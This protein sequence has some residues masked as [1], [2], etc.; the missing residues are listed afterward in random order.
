MV[1]GL[2]KFKEAFAAYTDNYVIIGGTACD[3]VLSGSSMRPRATVDIDVIIIVEKMTA[4]FVDAFWN[5]I[6]TCI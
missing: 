3:A 5:F 2:E 1:Y 6:R 4:E